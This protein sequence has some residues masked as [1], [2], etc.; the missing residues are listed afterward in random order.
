MANEKNLTEHYDT[1]KPI[2]AEMTRMLSLQY[3]DIAVRTLAAAT[4]DGYQELKNHQVAQQDDL[5][6][7]KSKFSNKKNFLRNQFNFRL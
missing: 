1:A 2:F 3:K 6:L 5:D 7:I 4:L